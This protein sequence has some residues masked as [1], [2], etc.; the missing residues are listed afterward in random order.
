MSVGSIMLLAR[1]IYRIN[2][3]LTN[4]KCHTCQSINHFVGILP[5][6]TWD[7]STR[8]LVS[9]LPVPHQQNTGHKHQLASPNLL[10]VSQT[11]AVDNGRWLRW[12][13]TPVEMRR[14]RNIEEEQLQDALGTTARR[15]QCHCCWR[16]LT[17]VHPIWKFYLMSGPHF[18][19]HNHISCVLRIWY[20]PELYT[21]M[22]RTMYSNVESY[23][24]WCWELCTE[25]LRT[26]Y[27]DVKNYIQRCWELYTEMLRTIYSDIE[28]NI[29]RCW[30]LC[31]EML[32][33]IYGY[34]K[35]YIRR[36]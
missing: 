1:N 30:E 18:W 36:C 26:I 9:A 21:E 17:I 20:T 7:G 34:A 31:T 15:P 4:R 19:K 13:A 3:E 32:R 33:T 29:Q 24:Q 6:G 11:L 14:W 12:R 35:N 23:I 5:D 10:Q 27:R 25:M 16:T 22:L 28:N 8:W 2:S